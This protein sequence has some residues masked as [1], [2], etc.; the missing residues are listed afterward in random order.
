MR[1]VF[2]DQS[3]EF[4]VRPSRTHIAG[5]REGRKESSSLEHGLG[6]LHEP[7]KS[8][9]VS[10]LLEKGPDLLQTLGMVRIHP[11]LLLRGQEL[12]DDQFTIQRDHGDILEPEELS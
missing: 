9:L 4:R 2:N 5:G 7:G 3:Q 1:R 8:L 11:R 12:T 10:L 6:I